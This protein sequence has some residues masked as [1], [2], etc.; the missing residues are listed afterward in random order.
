MR[1]RKLLCQR[2]FI[3]GFGIGFFLALTLAKI[4]S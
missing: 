2:W 1:R 3:T 4:F